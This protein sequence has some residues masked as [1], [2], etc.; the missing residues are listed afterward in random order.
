MEYGFFH[1]FA[2]QRRRTNQIQGLRGLDDQLV[3]TKEDLDNI[4]KDYFQGL[5]ATRGTGNL[6]RIVSGVKRR[7]SNSMNQIIM[8]KYSL[9]EIYMTLKDMVLTK[10]PGV[11]G[12]P[13]LCFQRYW[14]IVG[15]DVGQFCLN[16]LNRGTSL[17]YVNYTHIVFIL[18]TE[19]PDNLLHFRPINL[20]TIIYKIISKIVPNHFQKVLDVCIDESQ[21]TFIIVRL[22][23]DN[24]LLA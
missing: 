14:H 7:V 9:E 18:K 11:D 24:V 12:L 15:Q 1:I 13:A 20:C 21:S 22:I 6:E 16:V 4:A 8:A 19:H 2:S 5:L 3:T 17:E 23:I 10:T